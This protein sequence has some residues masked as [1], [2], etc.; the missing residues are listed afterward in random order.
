MEGD[1]DYI[2]DAFFFVVFSLY[3]R[4]WSMNSIPNRLI[5]V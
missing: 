5:I 4:G 2:S 1:V 3:S